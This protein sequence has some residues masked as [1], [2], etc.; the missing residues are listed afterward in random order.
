MERTLATAIG[1]HAGQPVRVAGWLHHQRVLSNVTFVLVR[2]R[3]G[4]AQVVVTDDAV[5]ASV[6]QL[7]PETVIEV[8]GTAVANVQAPRGFEIVDPAFTVMSAPAALPPFEL[9]R[10]AIPAQLP[11]LL[12]HAAVALRHPRRRAIA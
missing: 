12:D 1:A 5:R 6:S 4:I 3:S 7:L 11:T 2:D 8:A 10:N 9:R